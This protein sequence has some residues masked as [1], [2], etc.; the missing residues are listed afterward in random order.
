MELE[1]LECPVTSRPPSVTQS[2]STFFQLKHYGVG[3]YRISNDMH[4]IF[5]A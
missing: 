4:I 2:I 3:L 5:E 1:N